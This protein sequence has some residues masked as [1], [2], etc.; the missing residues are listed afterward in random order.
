MKTTD[1]TPQDVQTGSVLTHPAQAVLSPTRPPIA[2]QSITRAVAFSLRKAAAEG[3]F[4]HPDRP[5]K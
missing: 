3:R 5:E 1:E 2:S 4:Q